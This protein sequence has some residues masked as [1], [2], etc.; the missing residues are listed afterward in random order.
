MEY[1]DFYKKVK[2]ELETVDRKTKTGKPIVYGITVPKNAQNPELGLEFVKFVIG[3]AGQKIFADMGQPPI[4]P[5]EGS[6]DMPE[7][8]Q[9]LVQLESVEPTTTPSPTPSPAPTPPMT[10]FKAVFAVTALLAVTYI[11]LRRRKE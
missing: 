3:D 6:G 1:A 10:G 7:E 2:L 4:V 11:L 5:P 9:S 8:L